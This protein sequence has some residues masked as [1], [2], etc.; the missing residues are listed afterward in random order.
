MD[1]YFLADVSN[2][3]LSDLSAVKEVFATDT[4]DG[5][6]SVNLVSADVSLNTEGYVTKLKLLMLMIILLM[7][8]NKFL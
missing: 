4:L 6:V 8:L 5:D 2:L 1:H 7:L 3:K